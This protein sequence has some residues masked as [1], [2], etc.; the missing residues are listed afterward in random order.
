MAKEIELQLKEGDLAPDFSA[1]SQDGGTVKLSDFRGR[2]VVLYF[3]PRDDTPG[4][5]KE[6]CGFRDEHQVIQKKKA[7]LLGVSTDSQKAHAKFADKYHLP[8]P[9]LVD[10]Q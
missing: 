5:T 8:F 1:L 10:D 3:Y 6:A 9:L 2:Y 4:C 7:V